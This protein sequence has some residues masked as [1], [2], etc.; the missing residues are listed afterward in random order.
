M[1]IRVNQ[2]ACIGC[3]ACCAIAE[4]LFDLNEELTYGTK[5]SD[6]IIIEQG[7]DGVGLYTGQHGLAGGGANRQGGES[8]VECQ[9]FCG[10]SVHVGGLYGLHAGISDGVIPELVA[11]NE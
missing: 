1:K 11:Q 2:E 5:I 9:P 6:E 4:D 8:I 10:Q 3:G 7:T